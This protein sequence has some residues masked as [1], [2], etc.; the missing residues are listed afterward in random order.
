MA[1][2]LN[3]F[4]AGFQYKDLAGLLN[5]FI[6]GFQYKLLN[7]FFTGFLY[8]DLAGLL[9][10]FIAGFQYKNVAG[11]LN[12]ASPDLLSSEHGFDWPPVWLNRG[13]VSW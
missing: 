4:F 8:K 10:R 7:R 3:R 6:A 9:N 1:S 5:R 13:F 11:L 2:L 12:R